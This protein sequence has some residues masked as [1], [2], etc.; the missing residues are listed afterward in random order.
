MLPS[1]VLKTVHVRK[2]VLGVHFERISCADDTPL[3]GKENTVLRNPV[4]LSLKDHREQVFFLFFFVWEHFQSHRYDTQHICTTLIIK[5][6]V[7]PCDEIVHTLTA[8]IWAKPRAPATHL[9]FATKTCNARH[10][11]WAWAEEGC[12]ANFIIYETMQHFP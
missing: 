1:R 6:F 12:K 2:A 5:A 8:M 11:L 7:P 10:Q 3:Y 9:V 4:H